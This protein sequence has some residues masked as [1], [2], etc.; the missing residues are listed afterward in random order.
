MP[1]DCRITCQLVKKK[2]MTKARIGAT[3]VIPIAEVSRSSGT[4]KYQCGKRR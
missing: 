3:S 4:V 2:C 1:T